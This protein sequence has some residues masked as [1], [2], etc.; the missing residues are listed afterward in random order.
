VSYKNAFGKKVRLSD[1]AEIYETD[2]FKKV[3]SKK[4][5]LN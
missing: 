1:S 2:L 4:P 5:F 3:L